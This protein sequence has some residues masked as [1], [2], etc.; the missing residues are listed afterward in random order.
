MLTNALGMIRRVRR[1]TYIIN[2]VLQCSRKSLSE[3]ATIFPGLITVS[4]PIEP[5]VQFFQCLSIRMPK[6]KM[7]FEEICC[8][9]CVNMKAIN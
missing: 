6:A 2:N 1:C 7:E 8:K 4:L 3:C 9:Y 5:Q